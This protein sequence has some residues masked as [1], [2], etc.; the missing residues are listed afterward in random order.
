MAGYWGR[1]EK[2]AETTRGGWL[3][4]GDLGSIDADG[5]VTMRGRLAEL[6]TVDGVDWFPR[7]VEEA[8]ATQPGVLLA[9]LIG[10]PN[11]SGGATPIAFVTERPGQT[12]DPV[13][14]KSAIA[15]L[16][17]Y[18]LTPLVIRKAASLPMTP[19]GK[20][21]KATLAAEAAA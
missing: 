14:L 11:P 7:D 13:A 1:P 6:V 21:A 5:Y 4:S 18:D 12:V 9:A 15:P 17:P 19:T 2:T 8:L 20:I 10:I 16:L 3:H